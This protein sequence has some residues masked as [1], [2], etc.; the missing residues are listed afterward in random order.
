MSLPQGGV[1]EKCKMKMYNL[2]NLEDEIK[3]W[4]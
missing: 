3:K 2:N 1:R 4:K